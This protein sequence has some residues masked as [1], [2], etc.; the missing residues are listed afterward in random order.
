MILKINVHA[1]HIF[2][3]IFFKEHFSLLAHILGVGHIV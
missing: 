3:I 2:F 1:F